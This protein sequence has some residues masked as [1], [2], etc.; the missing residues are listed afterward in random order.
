MMG[1]DNKQIR[2]PTVVVCLLRGERN[3]PMYKEVL[4][5]FRMPS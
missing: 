3:Y 4:Q 5:A 2:H 1:A